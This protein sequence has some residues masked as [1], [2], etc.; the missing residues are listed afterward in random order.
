MKFPVY[1]VRDSYVGFGMPVLR[2]NDSVATRAFEFDC[3]RSDSPYSVRPECYQLY[4]IGEFDTDTG[5]ISSVTPVM[6][7]S[8]ND[9]VKE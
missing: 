1:C 7:A 9:F 4:Y 8:A 2:D 6:I 5:V 3:T